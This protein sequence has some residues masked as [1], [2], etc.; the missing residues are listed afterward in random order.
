ME[1]DQQ[2]FNASVLQCVPD[3][4]QLLPVHVAIAA[5]GEGLPAGVHPALDIHLVPQLLER[6]HP[7]PA[8][9]AEGWLGAQHLTVLERCQSAAHVSLE[10]ADRQRA[11][12]AFALVPPQCLQGLLRVE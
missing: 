10:R 4:A 8:S 5:V 12:S 11:P 2:A 7:M 3:A 6:M 9:P 1:L